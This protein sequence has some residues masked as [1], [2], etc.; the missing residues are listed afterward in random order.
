MLRR[1]LPFVSI[2]V[3]AAVAYDGW[4]FYGRWSSAREGERQRQSAEQQRDRQT[5]EMLGGTSFRIIN[6]YAAPQEIR[7][8]GQ[9]QLCFGV[10]GAKTVR[11]EPGI[12]AVHPALSYCL[13]VEPRK[14]TEYKL[15]AE[16][17]E[18]HTVTASASVKV[19]R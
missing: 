2:A 9:G 14:D 13:Q 7:R 3:L 4:I 17:G 19:E 12:G 18:G 5:I 8:G 11:I 16:D 6:F 10:Y 1:A 15:T